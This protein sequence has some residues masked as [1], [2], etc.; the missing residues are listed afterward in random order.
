[1]PRGFPWQTAYS[2]MSVDGDRLYV[3]LINKSGADPV[4][5]TDSDMRLST[6]ISIDGFDPKP[7]A[8]VWTLNG[9]SLGAAKTTF[10]NIVDP[11]PS[12]VREHDPDAFGLYRSRI[13]NAARKFRYTT[14][15]HSV[16]VIELER[17]R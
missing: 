2:S 5:P 15:A 8:K 3:M 10:A 6:T 9:K 13:G 4:V 12:E 17:R 16:S 7:D 14:P 1:M 11:D